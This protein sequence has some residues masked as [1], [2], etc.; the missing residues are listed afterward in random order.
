[1]HLQNEKLGKEKETVKSGTKVL[2]LKDSVIA[3]KNS[4]QSFSSRL[5]HA[6]GRIIKLTEVI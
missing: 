2:E 3:Q 6:E 5:D 4:I 1:M